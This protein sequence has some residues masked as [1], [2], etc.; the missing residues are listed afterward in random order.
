MDL[1]LCL[2][3]CM[4]IIQKPVAVANSHRFKSQSMSDLSLSTF[5]PSTVSNL[6]YCQGCTK[7][8]MLSEGSYTVAKRAQLPRR[9]C[10]MSLMRSHN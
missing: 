7:V 9:P 8:T 1:F 3:M 5:L 6:Y 4:L 2:V 10:T